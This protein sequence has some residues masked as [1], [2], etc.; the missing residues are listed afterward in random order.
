MAFGLELMLERILEARDLNATILMLRFQAEY[1]Q[2]LH[3]N[4]NA[5]VR[6]RH[7]AF[8]MESG[9]ALKTK[10]FAKAKVSSQ[11]SSKF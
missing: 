1:T 10:D 2:A 6:L 3:F 5:K 8:W 4:V 11:T 7:L 9:N